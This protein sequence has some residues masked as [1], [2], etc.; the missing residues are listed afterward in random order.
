MK[1]LLVLLA[2]GFE[3]VEAL[4]VVDIARRAHLKVDIAGTK[5]EPT[6]RVEG[7]HGIM[8][9]ADVHFDDVQDQQYRAV[10]I[11]GGMGGSTHLAAHAGV[12]RYLK[13]H[14]RDTYIAAIC[15]GPMVLEAAGLTAD[16]AGTHYP[17]LEDAIHYKDRPEGL[18]IRDGRIITS[19]GPATAPVLGLYLVKLL[20]GE[21]AYA[22]LKDDILVPQLL[23]GLDQGNVFV[24]V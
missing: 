4:S 22:A 12:L 24:E 14:A 19:M 20:K 11:P 8:V 2:P 17:G 10:Y 6:C 15:A 18:V 16:I 9:E 21:K 1:D 5:H 7:A 23:A 3:E 13:A